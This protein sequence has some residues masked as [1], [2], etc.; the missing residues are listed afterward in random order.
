MFK[1]AEQSR[2]KFSFLVYESN[3][4]FNAFELFALSG[5]ATN[6][7]HTLLLKLFTHVMS[8]SN[9]IGPPLSLGRICTYCRARAGGREGHVVCTVVRIEPNIAF[10]YKKAKYSGEFNATHSAP[11][12]AR[13]FGGGKSPARRVPRNKTARDSEQLSGLFLNHAYCVFF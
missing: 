1:S 7:P 2:Q 11:L 5:N 6:I 13:V 9:V 8:L 10:I 4:R 3:I 12:F